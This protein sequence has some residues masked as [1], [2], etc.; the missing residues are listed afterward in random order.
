M[1]GAGKPKVDQEIKDRLKGN[2]NK[3][4]GYLKREVEMEWSRGGDSQQAKNVYDAI[5]SKLD[6]AGIKNVSEQALRSWDQGNSIPSVNKLVSL[7]R[8]FRV[9]IDELIGREPDDDKRLYEVTKRTRTPEEDE[10]VNII[11][12]ITRNYPGDPLEDVDISEEKGKRILKDLLF[13][14]VI[15]VNADNIESNEGLEED[16]R[17]L[18]VKKKKPLNTVRVFRLPGGGIKRYEDISRYFY[19]VAAANFL[20]KKILSDVVGGVRLGVACGVTIA[21]IMYLLKRGQLKHCTLFPL[22]NTSDRYTIGSQAIVWDTEFRHEGFNVAAAD[23]DTSQADFLP[24][25]NVLLFSVGDNSRSILAR[26][27]RKR[28]KA[29]NEPVEPFNDWA[30]GDVLFNLMGKDGQVYQELMENDDAEIPPTVKWLR[31]ILQKPALSSGI[32][33]DALMSDGIGLRKLSEYAQKEKFKA[34]VMN[35]GP[36]RVEIARIALLDYPHKICN[37][38]IV[39]EKLAEGLLE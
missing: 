39:D 24:I 35:W 18:F 14:N 10:L 1:A 31:E 19:Y 6:S 11:W 2:I 38:L 32:S 20:A 28:L 15:E 25:A 22:L 12:R 29:E 8:F 23:S 37:H 36:S 13:S 9:S 7:A 30:A 33:L 34:V 21:S 17:R 27:I 5:S 3:Y 26:M 16:L 4:L